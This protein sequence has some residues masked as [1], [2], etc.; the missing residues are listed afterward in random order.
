M[1]KFEIVGKQEL[2]GEIKISGAK[3]S[4][5]KII[6][7]S[8]LAGTP[9]VINNIPDIVDIHKLVKILKSIGADIS[10]SNHTIDINPVPINSF[11]PDDKLVKKLRGSIVLIGPLLSRF[12]EAV[13]SNPGGCLIG[14]RP[15][16]DHLDLFK[17][18]GIH[19][20]EKDGV[21]HLVGKPKAGDIILNKLSVTA[22]EN[23]IMAT[24]LSSGVTTINVAAAEPEIIDLANFL[25]KMG[26]NIRGAGTHKVTINGV[27]EL[28]GTDYEIMPDR[29]EAE[30]Y[31]IAAIA[32][33]SCLRI[34]PVNSE[35]MSIVAKKLHSSGA[36]FQFLKEN[37]QEFI[38][39]EK[40]ET[41]AGCNIDT[42]TYPGF[43]TDIQSP[44]AVLMTQAKGKTEIFETLFEGRFLYLDELKIMGAD[45]EVLSPHIIS[46][47]GPTELKGSEIYSRDIRGG[48]ALV[49]AGLIAEGTTII[50][51]IEYIDRG[52]ETMDKKFQNVGAN[53]KRVD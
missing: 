39:T 18:L 37:D 2:K 49:I 40:H 5:L 50:E 25:N 36:N 3:N 14:S 13:F 45:I 33:N 43:P 1:A 30:T 16:D 34:G 47:S 29:I 27:S 11:R 51:D 44:Y 32:T 26:A 35:Y 20:S 15:I 52:Y 7:A 4:A 42:R 46:I 17:Q 19:I 53:I 24:V 10:F 48:A 41:L 38:Q 28:H 21:Y 31:L 12:G 8:I 23:A 22:T 6:P 9:S